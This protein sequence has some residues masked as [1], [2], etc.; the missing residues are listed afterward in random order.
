VECGVRGLAPPHGSEAGILPSASVL[1]LLYAHLVVEGRAASEQLVG[2]DA[3]CPRV[4]SPAVVEQ[5]FVLVLI[6]A[7]LEGAAEH[8]GRLGGE[9]SKEGGDET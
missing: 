6:G 1:A 4:N 3:D 5:L 7:G 9:K 2:H 8:L